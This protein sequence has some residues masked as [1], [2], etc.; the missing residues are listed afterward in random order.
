MS[1]KIGELAGAS[2]VSA[3]T[4]RFWEAEGLL[5]EP[6]RTDSGYR[7]YEETAADRLRFIRQA[8][9]AGLTLGQIRQILDV[10][11]DGAAPCKHVAAAVAQRLGEVE[12]RI[13][14][15]EATRRHLRRLGTKAAK[16]DPALCEGFCSIIAT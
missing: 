12:E 1:L 14:E 8:Q 4:I 5:P 13:A 11:D 15:L 7:N 10:S 6:A 3:K 16:Q 9:T 2:G